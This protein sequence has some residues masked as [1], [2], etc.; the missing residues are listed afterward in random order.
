M[1]TL[2]TTLPTWK[3]PLL[4]EKGFMARSDDIEPIPEYCLEKFPLLADETISQEGSQ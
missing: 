4:P 1:D 3:K 2:I